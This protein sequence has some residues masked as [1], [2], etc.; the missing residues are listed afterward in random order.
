MTSARCFRRSMPF[1]TPMGNN[2]PTIASF[3]L[4]MKLS[5]LVRLIFS[6][7]A[8]IVIF[9]D[10]HATSDLCESQLPQLKSGAVLVD[11]KQA[12]EPSK[13]MVEATILIDAP[14][15]SIWQVMVNCHEIPTFVPGLKVCRVLAAGDNWD[16]L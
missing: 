15:E 3:F 1:C 12:D 7:L 9:S 5:L 2:Q 16:C 6:G 8:L 13:G 4:G 10:V 14:A 11:I